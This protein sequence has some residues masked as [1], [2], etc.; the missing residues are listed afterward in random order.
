M[1]TIAEIEAAIVEELRSREPRFRVCGSLAQFL[2]KGIEDEATLCPAAFVAYE[3]GSYDHRMNGVQER[4]ML[5]NVFVMTR[6]ARGTK[7]QGT[8]GATK[9]G[10]T[11]CLTPFAG[12]DRPGLRPAHRPSAAQGRTGHRRRPA[13]LGLRHQLR[14]PLP[15][16]A[17]NRQGSAAGERSPRMKA[18]NDKNRPPEGMTIAVRSGGQYR[19]NADGTPSR[20]E[21]GASALESDLHGIRP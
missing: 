21:N 16:C 9:R 17:L 14:N 2:L 11:S 8:A 12:L 18:K 19:L 15:V 20:P 7:P 3:Q 10:F 5:F 13:P 1:H 6:N 4:T